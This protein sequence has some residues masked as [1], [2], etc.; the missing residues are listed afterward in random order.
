[1]SDHLAKEAQRLKE[2]ET[3]QA[4]LTVVRS[5]ALEQLAEAN[6]NDTIAILRLQQKVAVIDDIRSELEGA[7]LRQ[8]SKANS[9][10]TFA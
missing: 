2:D 6:A 10:G 7:I 4:A 9:P 3:F 1:M 5:Q 8:A